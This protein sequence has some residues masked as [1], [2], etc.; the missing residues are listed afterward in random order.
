MFIAQDR[1]ARHHYSFSRTCTYI[2]I[3]NRNSDRRFSLSLSHVNLDLATQ[4]FNKNECII[5]S[6][7][8]IL[9]LGQ[10]HLIYVVIT[11]M[12]NNERK[13]NKTRRKEKRSQHIKANDPLD[14]SFLFEILH[15]D[16]INS[17]SIFFQ[18]ITN[19]THTQKIGIEI[20]SFCFKEKKDID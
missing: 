6:P 5:C 10:R 1:C 19:Y 16:E 13:T 15:Q 18:L 7:S 20:N 4:S 11:Y 2:Y 12:L 17:R 3:Y 14:V 9:H 8:I